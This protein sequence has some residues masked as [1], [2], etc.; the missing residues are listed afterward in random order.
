MKILCVVGARPNFVKMAPLHQALLNHPVIQPKIVHTGQ[1]LGAMSDVFFDQLTL[2]QPDYFLGVHGGT[3]NQQMA[4]MLQKFELVLIKEQPDWVVVFG[5]VT[6]TLACTLAAAQQS[7]QIAHVEAGLR[8]GDPQM[9][10]ERNRRLTDALS[11]LLFVTEPAG[12]DNLQREG[13]VVEKIH[14][15]GNIMIDALI[16]HRSRA[17]Q[18]DIVE[19]LGL[20][21]KQYV[22]VTMH[23]PA[24]VDSETSLQTLLQLLS[25]VALRMPV[26]WPMHPRTWAN[27]GKFNLEHQLMRLPNVRVVEPQGYLECLNLLERAALVIT[28]SGGIQEE[29]TYLQVP[30]LTVRSTTE[31]PITVDI[32]TNELLTDLRAEILNEKLTD[33]LTGRWKVSQIPS[34]WDGKTAE[35]IAQILADRAV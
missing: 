33:V 32:G 24:N 30:C 21:P 1:H 31:R 27:L 11:D 10:E 28:D 15:V 25:T 26:V 20:T 18:C 14:F 8:S 7:V 29:T 4:L 35:R 13:V 6:S 34:L 17:N 16:E 23:R 5:D 9:P 2:P 22:L 12:V 3:P 19:R